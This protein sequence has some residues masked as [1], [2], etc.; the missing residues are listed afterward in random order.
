VRAAG[1]LL[2]PLVALAACTSAAPQAKVNNDPQ[3]GEGRLAGAG[4]TFQK[5]LQ[6]RWINDFTTRCY[7]ATVTYDPIGSG[8]GI[9]RF[10]AGQVDFAGSD[11]LLTADEQRRADRRCTGSAPGAV[12]AAHIPLAGG[13]LV[14]LYNLPGIPSLRLS[15]ATVAAIFQQEV[16]TWNDPRIAA[17]NAG[18]RLPDL[19]I[20]P[21]HRADS[22]GSTDILTKFLSASTGAGWR[23]GVGKTLAW[24]AG[25]A[26]AEHSDGVTDAVARQ[27]GAVTYAE[28]SF[29]AALGLPT[30]ALRNP[31]GYYVKANGASVAAALTYTGLDERT[32]DPR[33]TIDYT[34]TG[35]TAYPASAVT[36]AIVC[37]LRNA[38]PDLL[39]S[40]L[41]Y[42][43]TAGQDST[44]SIGYAPL[45]GAVINRARQTTA[46]L[47]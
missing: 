30:A 5:N 22:S 9:E 6:L 31:A 47:G 4:A 28:L 43:L 8:G 15:P 26:G 29:A 14:F 46:D 42:A 25:S 17:D 7:A 12:A 2:A 41:S 37:R 40:Y 19:P 39:R 36:Y 18:A 11:A 27:P 23:L 35:P 34:P 32:Q 16:R 1:L 33:L 3:C 38:N 24:P 44:S 10:I 21:V 45:G 13:A 20:R